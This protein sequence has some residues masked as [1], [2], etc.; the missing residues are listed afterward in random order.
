MPMKKCPY[1]AEEIQDE[2]VKCKHC[3][4]WFNKKEELK[5]TKPSTDNKATA[6]PTP[7][8]RLPYTFQKMTLYPDKFTYKDSQ[9]SYSQITSIYFQNVSDKVYALWGNMDLSNSTL[10]I[11]ITPDNT[12]T[13][14]GNSGFAGFG[15]TRYEV[16]TV[17]EILDENDN[18]VAI[19]KPWWKRIF[20]L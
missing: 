12:I 17:Y 13:I 19:K 15:D 16:L 20:G 18:P 8:M 3:G 5:F 10:K 11:R 4:E 1:C 6:P 2:A 14:Y 9:Y 7:K